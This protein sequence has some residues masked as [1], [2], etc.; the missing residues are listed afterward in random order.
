MLNSILSLT[1]PPEI[2]TSP[3]IDYERAKPSMVTW[4]VRKQMLEAEDRER[5]KLLAERKRHEEKLKESPLTPGEANYV[6]ETIDSI[7]KLEEELGLETEVKAD[8]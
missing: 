6:K 5:A 8:A 1:K 2:E 3:K 7:E 4:R